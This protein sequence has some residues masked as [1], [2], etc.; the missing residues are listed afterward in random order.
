MDR[1]DGDPPRGPSWGHGVAPHIRGTQWFPCSRSME[2]LESHTAARFP[3]GHTRSSALMPTHHAPTTV[4]TFI[5]VMIMV[6]MRWL[7]WSGPLHPRCLT[8]VPI[9]VSVMGSI[10]GQH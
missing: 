5:V 4:L 3:E 2:A 7:S 9:I 1:L 8:V 10:M 6:G